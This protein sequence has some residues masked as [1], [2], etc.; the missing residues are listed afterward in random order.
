[1][2]LTATVKLLPT[3]EQATLL[4]DTLERANAACNWI[5]QQA[6]QQRVF[7]Q[8]ALHRL[9]YYAARERFGLGA[10]VIVRCIAK[11]VQAYKPDHETIRTFALHGAVAFDDRLLNWR[12]PDRAVSIWTPDGR[13]TIPFAAGERQ[14]ALLAFQ[15]GE[16]DLLYRNGMFLLTATCDV[17]DD[18]PED[19][20]DFLG[21]DL[22]VKNIAYSWSFADLTAKI[23]YKARRY[24][25]PVEYIDPRNTS[26]QC[27]VC[28]HVDKASRQSQSRFL[29]TACGH[30]TH[31]DYNAALNIRV[32]ANAQWSG[33]SVNPPNEAQA[34]T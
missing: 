21:A 14:L 30:A 4:K 1:M 9:T 32:K 8:I 18:P 12:V 26:R 29:C 23:D 10:Q 22:G 25:V 5:S 34:S 6:W 15:K 13:Q 7:G 11:V 31:A 20:A 27:S 3:P 17:P 28:G 24:G 19:I 2:K 33:R 16:S